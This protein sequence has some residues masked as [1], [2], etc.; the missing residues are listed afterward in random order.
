MSFCRSGWA[1]NREAASCGHLQ[2][3]IVENL[4][5][6]VAEAQVAKFDLASDVT[7]LRA[8]SVSGFRAARA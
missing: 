2:V 4:L 8:G 3:H 5:A 1:Y 7:V 6:V